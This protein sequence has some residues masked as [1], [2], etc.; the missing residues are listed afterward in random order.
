MAAGGF[1]RWRSSWRSRGASST[2]TSTDRL[3]QTA[4]QNLARANEI[5]L[6]R[7]RDARPGDGK[8]AGPPPVPLPG[9][10][11]NRL[12]RKLRRHGVPREAAIQEAM[13]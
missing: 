7:L 8:P 12:Y 10:S 11:R 13:R 2:G 9:G 1:F 6:A 3:R 5:R 4:R